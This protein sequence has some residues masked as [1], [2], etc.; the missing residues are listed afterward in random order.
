[1]QRISWRNLLGLEVK[2]V[3]I[4]DKAVT[5]AKV[6]ALFGALVDCSAAAAR[7]NELAATDGVVEVVLTHSEAASSRGYSMGKTDAASPPTAIRGQCTVARHGTDA[8]EQ[9]P[10]Y[11]SFSMLVKKGDRWLVEII[12]SGGALASYGVYWIPL[13]S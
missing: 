1:M 13:G 3:N 12:D 4:D 10:K 8:A 2:A 11:G 6:T 7:D 9:E 5:A